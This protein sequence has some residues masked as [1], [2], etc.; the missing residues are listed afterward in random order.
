MGKGREGKRVTVSPRLDRVG[1]CIAADCR[2]YLGRGT[3]NLG[4]AHP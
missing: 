4:L 1:I 2:I 3:T